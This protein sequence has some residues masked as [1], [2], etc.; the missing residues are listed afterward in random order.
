MKPF[1]EIEEEGYYTLE[2]INEKKIAKAEEKLGVTLPDTYKRLILEQNG[3]YILHNAFPTTHP[4]SWAEDHIPFNH[5]LGIAE[6]EGILD[7]AYLIKEWELPEGLVLI[8]GEGHTWVAMDYRKTK[9]HPP[10]H[11]FDLEMEDDFKLADSFD[12]FI[13]GLYTAEEPMVEV[14][15]IDYESSDVYLSKEELKYIFETEVLDENNLYRIQYYPMLEVEEIE[16]FFNR[17]KNHIGNVKDEDVLYEVA[18]T[19]NSILLLNPDMPSNDHIQV[20]L[21]EIAEFLEKNEDP[22]LVNLGEHIALKAKG[23]H[24]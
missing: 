21:R 13:E 20:V 2:K 8:S 19:I 10:I 1:W 11:Y 22:L 12:Q 18:S 16:W 6:D 7:S 5:L 9:E 15:E 17:M 4:N 24:S 14:V 3:G 23:L